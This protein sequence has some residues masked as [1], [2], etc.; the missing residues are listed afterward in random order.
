MKKIIL[1]LA[2]ISVPVISA[3]ADVKSLNSRYTITGNETT[4]VIFDTRT[5]NYERHDHDIK[6][7][8]GKYKLYITKYT[9]KSSTDFW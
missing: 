7:E 3:F 9:K 4:F 2:M 1:V 6:S 8:K 5:G